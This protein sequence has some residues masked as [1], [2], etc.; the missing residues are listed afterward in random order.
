VNNHI[1]NLI[2]RAACLFQR[3]CGFHSLMIGLHSIVATPTCT[4]LLRSNVTSAC[5]KIPRIPKMPAFKTQATIGISWRPQ[6]NSIVREDLVSLWVCKLS[7]AAHHRVLPPVFVGHARAVKLT[8]LQL[9]QKQNVGQNTLEF[10]E[11]G[12]LADASKGTFRA[13]CHHRSP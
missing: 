5:G 6:L 1:I 12:V 9:L 7:W 4:P 3:A 2:L 13:F 8:C 11:P 10:L